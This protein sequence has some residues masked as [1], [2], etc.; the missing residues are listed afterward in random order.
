MTRQWKNNENQL[1][2]L[3][4]EKSGKGKKC[5]RISGASAQLT[6]SNLDKQLIKWYRS[7][8]GMDQGD[9]N[10][11]KEK[12]MLKGLIR[13]G[14]R[15]CSEVKSRELSMKWYTRFLQRHRLSVQKPVRKQ[16][17][18][19]PE[20]HLLIEQF[21]SFLR[22]CSKLGP[23]GGPMGC[24]TE[25][26]ACNVDE[27]PLNSWGGQSKRCI[28]DIN[29]KN[30]IE[31]HLDDKRFGTVILWVFPKDNHRV[32]PVFLFKGKG[33]ISATEQKQYSPHVKVF[34]TPK[35]VINTLTMEQ[36]M[37]WWFEKVKDGN[38]KLFITDSCKMHLNDDLKRRM[39][40]NGV[41]LAVIS[42]GCTQYVQLLDVHVFSVFKN[43]YYDC[44]EEYIELNSPRSQLKLT[45]S[46]KR[47]LCTRLT[48]SAWFRTLKSIDLESFSFTWLYLS[49]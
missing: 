40:A 22:S 11:S 2:K 44:A 45:S 13:Q 41:C 36:Y 46:R 29:T 49:R 17:F 21:H 26:D 42:K 10:V 28:N 33:G 7:K 15:F 48:A 25:S 37:S 19:L 1:I 3:V 39:R 18:S 8:R 30:E 27:S 47:I 12:V 32:Q 6:Y 20:A 31:G 38:R 35:S 34:F 16:N 43:H 23:Q 9:V 14:Q 5:K 4:K 24:F